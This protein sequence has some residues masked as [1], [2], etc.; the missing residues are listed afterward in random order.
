MRLGGVEGTF[1]L[2][3]PLPE[4]AA[5]HQRR[6]RH[7]ADHEHAA[8]AS[9]AAARWTTSCTSTPRARTTDVIFGEQL[10]E[11]GRAQPR[12]PPARAADRRARAGSGPSDL[13]AL[14]A[15]LG[16][17]EAF[18][19]GPADMLDA[20]SEH[21]ERAGDC[22]RLHIERFQ[23]HHRPARTAS[24]ARAARSRSSRATSRPAATAPSR[25]SSPARRRAPRCPTDAGWA[26]ATPASASSAVRQDPRPAHGR[27]VRPARARSCAPA[28]TPPRAPSRSPFDPT[29]KE[30][31]AQQHDREPARA[32]ERRADRGARQGVR[33][34]P[35]RG[36]RRARRPRPP[37]HR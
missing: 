25:S 20:L 17:R 1:V 2:P 10:R 11:H 23:P 28:S 22:D 18:I 14:C 19:S 24:S 30:P 16:E 31:H 32:A 4:Q 21:W 15:R 13:A 3:D 33:R 37:L 36:L 29:R 7:H 12:L 27:G 8:R 9:T 6:Q 5:V 26:S 34:H 35:R